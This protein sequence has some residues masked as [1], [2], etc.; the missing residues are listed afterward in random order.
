MFYAIKRRKERKYLNLTLI[1]SL[2][3]IIIHH[4]PVYSKLNNITCIYERFFM[5]IGAKWK[6]DSFRIYGTFSNN[7][8][9]KADHYC[10]LITEKYQK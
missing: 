8:Y 7:L 9:N 2:N 4:T 10:R 3:L 6:Y 5:Y 1:F